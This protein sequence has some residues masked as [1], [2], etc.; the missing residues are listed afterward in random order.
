[1][2]LGVKEIFNLPKMPQRIEVY[3][4]SHTGG[5]NT[6]GAL[7]TAGPDGFIKNG[8]RKFN[9]RFEDKEENSTNRD[10]TAMMREVLNR[11]FSK[12]IKKEYPDLNITDGGKGQ[13]STAH[14]ILTELKVNIP[15][16]CISKGEKRNAGEENF[17]QI[18][19]E[20]FTLPKRH[21]VMYYLQ[22]LRDEAHRFAITTHRKKRSNSMFAK[23]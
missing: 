18:G 21:P 2:L 3:D 11:R 14:Q 7:I 1:M 22:R 10:D 16:I 19:Q 23:E 15:L 5:T 13:L 6:V 20:S 4:N 9:I 17:H 12:L 8:Y